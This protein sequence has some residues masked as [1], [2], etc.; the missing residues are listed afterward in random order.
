MSVP[1]AA[2]AATARGAVELSEVPDHLLE[3]RQLTA[4]RR[5]RPGDWSNL[6]AILQALV[7]D[8]F[9]DVLVIEV[10]D[11]HLL[12]NYIGIKKCELLGSPAYVVPG[13]VVEDADA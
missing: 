2:P 7:I 13:F 1:A 11:I 5:G 8:G 9:N 6:L 10:D 3:E 12:V 4:G